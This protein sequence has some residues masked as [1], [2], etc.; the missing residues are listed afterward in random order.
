MEIHRRFFPLQTFQ[1][2]CFISSFSVSCWVSGYVKKL[3]SSSKRPTAWRPWTW[4]RHLK[5][6]CTE[7]CADCGQILVPET[8]PAACTI[9]CS[10][11]DTFPIS[12]SPS[13]Y[14][15]TT[16]H[17][18]QPSAVVSN[19]PSALCSGLHED[20]TELLRCRRKSSGYSLFQLIS[21]VVIFSFKLLLR[22]SSVQILV[23]CSSGIKLS[24]LYKSIQTHINKL[25][26][27][28]WFSGC[29]NGSNRS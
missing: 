5:P 3:L 12:N 17:M 15:T 22:K 24:P 4:V 7:I 14:A 18:M 11:W 29:L 20:A 27:F 9:R 26:Y 25:K 19:T 1:P 6:T 8:C 28:R 10:S 21:H 13:R 23:E 2:L 16:P